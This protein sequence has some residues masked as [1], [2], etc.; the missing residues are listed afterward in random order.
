MSK[1]IISV[2]T[3]VYN[4]EKYLRE[5]MDSIFAQTL[6]DFEFVIINDGSTDRTE[7][8][9]KSYGDL[10]IRYCANDKNRGVFY[11]YNR[12]IDLAKGDFLAVA[13][14]DD[15]SHPR[16]LEIQLAYMQANVNVGLVCSKQK[17]F[18]AR[19]VQFAKITPPPPIAHNAKQNKHGLLF[20]SPCIFH[21]SVM[22]RKST[23]TEHKVRYDSSYKIAGDYYI[24]TTLNSITDMVCLNCFLLHYRVHENNFS[25]N[26]A[27][28]NREANTV[29]KKFF[30]SEFGFTMQ[31]KLVL[32]SAQI[33]LADFAEHIA[34]INHILAH[35]NMHPDYD[36]NLL[37]KFAANLGYKYLKAVM[38][39][40]INNKQA[41]HLYWQTPLLHHMD[42][43]K[44]MR[45][46]VKY[47]AHH[48]GIKRK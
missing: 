26:M 19:P 25:G 41:F 31:G 12:A 8:I 9:I 17:I 18:R 23:L 32:E 30:Q 35:T 7:E 15:I 6:Q 33:S 39:G 36:Q 13:E 2:L 22:Y 21:A 43:A 16:R 1:P 40:G 3:P 46:W 38:K 34:G 48:L 11:T 47:F 45:L 10:R 20:Y 29:Y 44:K 28:S 24:Y 4:G 5:M 27:E 37:A 14:A 42:T